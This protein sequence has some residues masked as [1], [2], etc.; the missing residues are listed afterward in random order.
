MELLERTKKLLSDRLKAG[1]KLKEIAASSKG[2]VE[3][4]WLKRF[5]NGAIEDPS[6]NRVQRLHD[7]LAGKRAA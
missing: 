2:E 3:Y 6:V 1:A 4:D 7:S 5:A